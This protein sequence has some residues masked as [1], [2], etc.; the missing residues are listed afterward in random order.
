VLTNNIHNKI[1]S[2]KIT[3]DYSLILSAMKNITEKAEGLVEEKKSAAAAL[4]EKQVC[5]Y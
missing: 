1:T 3:R 4:L 5:G 2:N